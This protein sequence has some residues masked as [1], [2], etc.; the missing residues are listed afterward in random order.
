[1]SSK[2]LVLYAIKGWDLCH[3]KTDDRGHQKVGSHKPSKDWVL[4]TIQRLILHAI[5]WWVSRAIKRLR[6]T[7]HQKCGSYMPSKRW[8]LCASKR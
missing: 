1:M 3:K 2:M 6:L 8:V 7:Y 4:Y 5:K